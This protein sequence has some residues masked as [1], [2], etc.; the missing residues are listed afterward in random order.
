MRAVLVE[1]NPLIADAL[2]RQ[3]GMGKIRYD[4]QDWAG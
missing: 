1:P 3:L 4:R 2:G